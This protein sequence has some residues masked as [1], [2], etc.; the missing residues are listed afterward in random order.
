MFSYGQ[1][2]KCADLLNSYESTSYLNNNIKTVDSE[3]TVGRFVFSKMILGQMH[4]GKISFTSQ[5]TETPPVWPAAS[6]LPGDGM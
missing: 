2:S 4:P 6:V 5:S 3:K 1:R